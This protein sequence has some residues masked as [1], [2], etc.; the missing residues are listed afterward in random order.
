MPYYIFGIINGYWA[1]NQK[2]KE[3][4]QNLT[5]NKYFRMAAVLIG[6]IIITVVI[7]RPSVW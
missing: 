4:M 1:Q 6:T 2:S 7:I 5:G 3:T